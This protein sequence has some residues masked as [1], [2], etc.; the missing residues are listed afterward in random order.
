LFF[1]EK[2]NLLLVNKYEDHTDMIGPHFDQPTANGDHCVVT[3]SL[4][5]TRG[6]S[7]ISRETNEVVQTIDMKHGDVLVMSNSFQ[8][9]YMHAVFASDVPCGTRIS[10]TTRCVSPFKTP[11][12]RT[13][14]P[15]AYER[16]CMVCKC[17]TK[18][19]AKVCMACYHIK[20][21]KC[22][23]CETPVGAPWLC[24]ACWVAKKTTSA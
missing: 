23:Q 11:L 1:K 24:E 16:L 20:K 12:V 3:I 6:Y 5:A 4:G 18:G 10:L 13:R 2:F 14:P 22:P 8:L 9:L 21:F 17:A 15:V 19:N 7:V